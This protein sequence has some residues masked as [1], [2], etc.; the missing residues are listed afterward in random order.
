MPFEPAGQAGGR[1]KDRGLDEGQ[2]DLGLGDG[3]LAL[4]QA[5]QALGFAVGE[6]QRVVDRV[7]LRPSV[8]QVQL[9]A[10]PVSTPGRLLIS[11]RKRPAGESTSAST[12][13]T[14]PSSSMNSKL[15]QTCQG[16][17]SGSWPRSQSSASRSH[18][19]LDSAMTCQ[20]AWRRASRIH[21][22]TVLNVLE[23]VADLAV[24][25]PAELLDGREIDP[26]GRLLVE[27]GDRAAIQPR[28]PRNV[29]DAKLVSAHER[30]EVAADHARPVNRTRVR[31]ATTNWRSGQPPA[32]G[33]VD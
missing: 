32:I 20:R 33:R 28:T 10:S 16:S 25:Q 31:K 15:V 4:E 18:A 21:L 2:A 11:T 14:L 27:R 7:G 29:R 19:K 24:E 5:G 30:G 23:K 17:R 26:R 8:V 22:A 9:C 1:Q 12:S 6:D 13:L 3:R